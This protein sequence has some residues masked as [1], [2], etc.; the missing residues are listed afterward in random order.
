M[1][2]AALDAKIAE[3]VAAIE[4]ADYALAMR[5]ALAAKALLAGT[6]DGRSPGESYSFSGRADELDTLIAQIRKLQGSGGGIQSSKLTRV[7]PS[8]STD[9]LY[10]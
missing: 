2:L 7:Y 9:S 3:V 1:G 8:N 6:P 5:K 10:A 4:D